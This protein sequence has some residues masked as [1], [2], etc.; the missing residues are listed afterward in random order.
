MM[1]ERLRHVVDQLAVLPEAEQDAFAAQ[2]EVELQEAHYVASQPADPNE[3]DL[4][5]LLARADEQSAQGKIYNL[6]AILE[7]V[8]TID[9][10]DLDRMSQAIEEGCEQIDAA[11]W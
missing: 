11:E 9:A 5:Y 6:D 7:F 3:T 2:L 8:D 1:I 4:D 10:A